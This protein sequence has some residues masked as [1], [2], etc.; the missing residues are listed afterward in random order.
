VRFDAAVTLWLCTQ[1]VTGSTTVW[2]FGYYGW[3]TGGFRQ[4]LQANTESTCITLRPMF[5]L[6]CAGAETEMLPRT[7]NCCRVDGIFQFSW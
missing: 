7:M 2:D 3:F 1:Q 4:S 5:P 6:S